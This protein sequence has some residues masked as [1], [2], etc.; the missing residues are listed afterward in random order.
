MTNERLLVAASAALGLV[1][2]PAAANAAT[3]TVNATARAITV[4]GDATPETITIADN[5]NVITVDGA[6][7]TAPANNTFNLTVNAG[8]GNDTVNVNT[9]ALESVTVNGDAGAD[10]LDGSAENDSDVER[11]DVPPVPVIVPNTVSVLTQNAVVRTKGGRFSTKLKLECS[12]TGVGDGA[13]R[14]TLLT[15]KRYR[16]KGVKTQLVL[17]SLRYHVAPGKTKTLTVRLPKGAK[18]LARKSF[19]D[20]IAQTNDRAEALALVF[21]KK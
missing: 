4:A 3:V 6:V 16:I 15:R 14:L 18:K 13:G 20:A 7:T 1:A 19:V 11:L 5:G 8:D 21:K 2:F 10:T 17:A 12:A 9:N